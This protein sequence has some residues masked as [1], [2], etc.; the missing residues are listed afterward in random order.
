MD[1]GMIYSLMDWR[2][3]E[4]NKW[5]KKTKRDILR[6]HKMSRKQIKSVAHIEEELRILILK[7]KK[8]KRYLDKEMHK[9]QFGKDGQRLK[10][11]CGNYEILKGNKEVADICLSALKLAYRSNNLADKC[12]DEEEW[13]SIEDIIGTTYPRKS[14]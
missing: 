5:F 11:Y 6:G 1:F 3:E 14:K 7:L 10:G 8:Y 12:C 2:R 13:Q 4:S 9:T